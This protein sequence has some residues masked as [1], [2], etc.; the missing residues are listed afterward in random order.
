MGART[1]TS[2]LLGLA[3]CGTL[4]AGLSACESGGDETPA[5]ADLAAGKRAFLAKC[6][7]CHTMN[8][9]GTKG[10]QGPDLDE[11]FRQALDDGFG[12]GGIRGIV[13]Y[14]IEHPNQQLRPSSP[15]YMPADLVKGP[16]V[17]NVAAYVASAAAKPGKD[18]GTLAPKSVPQGTDGKTIFTQM[19]RSC[20]TLAEAG[21]GGSIGPNLDRVLPGQ[22]ADAIAQSIRDPDAVPSPGYQPGIMPRNYGDQL[23][24]EQI[25][26]LAEYLRQAAGK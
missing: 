9:A 19:C 20:H 21:T 2:R 14:Q 12:R 8:R 11:A 10:K 13:A 1:V 22:D 16:D 24:R 26:A 17:S 3:V 18:T 4:I 7:T 23:R 5:T 25:T 6:G 15:G